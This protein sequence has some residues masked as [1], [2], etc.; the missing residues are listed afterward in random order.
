MPGF[1]NAIANATGIQADRQHVDKP[2]LK[3]CVHT[4]PTRNAPA[5]ELDKR[6]RPSRHERTYKCLP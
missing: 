1:R 5:G 6:L 3:Q 4:H 2:A